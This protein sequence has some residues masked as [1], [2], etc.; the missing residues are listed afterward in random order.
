MEVL[1]LGLLGIAGKYISERFSNQ[2]DEQFIEEDSDYEEVETNNNFDQKD[3]VQNTMDVLAKKKKELSENPNNNNIIPNLYNK[4]KYELDAE[5]KYLSAAKNNNFENTIGDSMLDLYKNDRNLMEGP[6][7]KLTTLDEQFSQMK[8]S[9][10]RPDASNMGKLTLPE[11]WTPYNKD[12]DDMTYKIFKK[13][14]LIHNNMQPFFKDRG[15]LI[16]E[17]NS[18]N[19]EQKLDIYTGSSRFYFQKKEVPNIVENFEFGFTTNY[20][21]VMLRQDTAGTPVQTDIFQDRYFSG[22]EK[23][24]Q[25]PF[26]DIKVTPGLNL[27]PFQDGKV[28]FHDPYQPPTVNIDDLRRKDNPQISYTQPMT[29]GMSG[30][31]KGSIIGRV[32][33]KKPQTFGELGVD[34]DVHPT[35][36]TV[37]KPTDQGNF[38]FD[39]SSRGQDE[40]V[41]QGPKGPGNYEAVNSSDFFGQARDVLKKYLPGLDQTVISGFQN[42]PNLDTSSYN[43]PITNRAK[44]NANYSGGIGSLSGGATEVSQYQPVVTQRL[45]TNSNYSGAMGSLSGGAIEVS[46]Y[47]PVNTIRMGQN[48]NYSGAIGSLSGGA[49]EVSQYQPVNTIRM[50]QNANY[51]G[52]L[53]SLNGGATE[54]SQYQPLYTQRAT[55]NANFTGGVGS[56]NGGN[57]EMSEYQAM[58]TLRANQNANFTGGL[59]SLNGGNGEMSEYQ[60]MATLRALQNANFTGGMGSL[61]GGNGEMSEYQALATLRALQN[62]NNLG[63]MGAAQGA[64]AGEV[65]EYQAMATLRALQQANNMGSMGNLTGGNGEVSNYQAMAT[66]RALQ[67]DNNMGTMGNLVGGNGEVSLYQ[68]MATLRALQNTNNLGIMGGAQGANAGEMSAYQATPTIRMGQNANF[69]GGIQGVG[70]VGATTTGSGERNMYFRDDKENLLARN[71]PTP[72]NAFQPPDQITNGEVELKSMPYTMLTSTGKLPTSDYLPFESRQKIIAIPS[73]YPNYNPDDMQY[74]NPFINNTLHK[75]KPNIVANMDIDSMFNQFSADQ[76]DPTRRN[77]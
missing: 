16:T 55:Q 72:V 17:D 66:L 35:R 46:Q 2:T 38:N 27:N 77:N 50:G 33:N 20:Q 39:K 1:A 13:E 44:S 76:I 74:N 43:N 60:A 15:M 68:A 28:G 65:S 10:K 32:V 62:A 73:T 23:R 56:L 29:K 8:I 21:P 59:G 70:G 52:A 42:L 26:D 30:Q 49:T 22:K 54:V 45:D 75:M 34:Y 67:Q 9:H 63:I 3:R 69:T 37:D 14:E 11:N 48:A 61:N 64:N 24:N 47:Q 7:N 5:N 40:S 36:A 12:D 18:R 57:G 4:R 19:M 71:P 58:A 25:K 51:S 41:E 6:V 53:G 31:G